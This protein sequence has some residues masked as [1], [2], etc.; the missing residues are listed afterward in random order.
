MS[1]DVSYQNGTLNL[2]YLPDG[3]VVNET[4]QDPCGFRKSRT[5]FS[6]SPGHPFQ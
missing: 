5:A 4:G 2:I 6:L 1:Q 3:R